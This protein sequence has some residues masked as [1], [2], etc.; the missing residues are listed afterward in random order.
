MTYPPDSR[1]AA[2]HLGLMPGY[3]LISPVDGIWS[4]K[5]KMFLRPKP[6]KSGYV[7]ATLTLSKPADSGRKTR[8]VPVHIVVKETFDGRTPEGQV[9]DHINRR[10]ADYRLENLRFTS[11]SGNSLNSDTSNYGTGRQRPVVQY[12]LEY[13]FV[14]QWTSATIA[15]LELQFGAD[16]ITACC[17]GVTGSSYGYIWEYH[18]PDVEGEQWLSIETVQVSNLGRIRFSDG[19]VTYGCASNVYRYIKIN[20]KGYA[21]HDLVCRAFHG[22]PPTEDLVVNHKDEDP[23]NNKPDNLEWLSFG[24]NIRYS[25]NKPVIQLQ[26]GQVAAEFESMT[27]A[28]LATGTSLGSISNVC[29]MKRGTAG[30]Y[31]WRLKYE[32]DQ[33]SATHANGK[34]VRQYSLAGEYLRTFTSAAEAGLSLPDGSASSIRQCCAGKHNTACGYIWREEGDPRPV[35]ACRPRQNPRSQRIEQLTLDGAHVAYHFAYNEASRATSSNAVQI[36]RCARGERA[37]Y[38]GF[39]WQK[40]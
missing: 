39:R 4:V 19:R 12:T 34:P 11:Y 18:E 32:E 6:A 14:R 29:R 27:A 9:I 40:A 7:S 17:R 24:D 1:P 15:A 5:R 38:G 20:Y 16:P 26:D 33:V 36:S 23:G 31:E 22:D 3:Y 21:V 28:S 8:T 35:A 25:H 10:R 37:D 30:G 2:E 13:D